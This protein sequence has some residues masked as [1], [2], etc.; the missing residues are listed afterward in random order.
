[1]AKI[2]LTPEERRAELASGVGADV[3]HDGG[4]GPVPFMKGNAQDVAAG[5]GASARDELGV[6]DGDRRVAFVELVASLIADVAI[7]IGRSTVAPARL[8]L[9]AGRSVHADDRAGGLAPGG[10]DAVE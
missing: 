8:A 9:C 10:H 6:F 2:D 7:E 3:L 5:A 1:M 4:T